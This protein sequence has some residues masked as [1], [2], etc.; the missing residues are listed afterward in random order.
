VTGS[1]EWVVLAETA[2]GYAHDLSGLPNQDSHLGAGLVIGKEPGILAAVADG[3]GSRRHFRSGTGS[4]LATMAA[5]ECVLVASADLV[6]DVTTVGAAMKLEQ[7]IAPMIVETWRS[8]VSADVSESPFTPEEESL[9]LTGDTAEIAYGSTLLV[10][11]WTADWVLC[12]Q[13]GDG[14]ILVVKSDASVLVPVPEDPNI[15][16]HRTTSL[17]QPDALESF[18]YAILDTSQTSPL[19]L[20]LSTD[21]FSNSRTGA[22]QEDVAAE[23]GDRFGTGG[24]PLVAD[25]LR[26]WVML[27]ASSDG[28]GD[29]TT[30]CLVVR[31]NRETS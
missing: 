17:C 13:I 29:D 15:I 19:A 2:R 3:H 28:S 31:E 27:S 12:L 24:V 7:R 25:G 10:G 6:E 11:V 26:S 22:W 9:R 5:R 20:M 23:I 16:G 1:E 4:R 21:G 18:R 8:S 14:D 30:V